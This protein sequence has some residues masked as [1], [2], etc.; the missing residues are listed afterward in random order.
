MEQVHAIISRA[1]TIGFKLYR[2]PG[3]SDEIFAIL[4]QY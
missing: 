4:K 1:E 2:L 3:A